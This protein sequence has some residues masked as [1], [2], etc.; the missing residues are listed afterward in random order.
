MSLAGRV[1]FLARLAEVQEAQ[2]W[3]PIASNGVGE[4]GSAASAP[5][6]GHRTTDSGNLLDLGPPGGQP[7]PPGFSSV[8][9]AFNG[10]LG[11]QPF[12]LAPNLIHHD[13]DA[14]TL[15]I[16]TPA[17]SDNSD[18]NDS[19]G[20]SVGRPILAEFHP[21]PHDPSAVLLSEQPV[22]TANRNGNSLGLSPF[23]G[24]SVA[25]E[26]IPVLHNSNTVLLGDQPIRTTN[27]DDGSS[28]STPPAGQPIALEFVPILHAPNGDKTCRCAKNFSRRDA[29]TRHIKTANKKESRTSTALPRVALELDQSLFPCG[30]CDKHQGQS[31]FAR[32]DHLRQHL[33][34]FHKLNDEAIN[35]CLDV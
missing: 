33:R 19:W 14:A 6:E 20:L 27:R 18:V 22:W 3:Q 2:Y 30:M 29:L 34:V 17:W 31:A 35:A 13:S 15:A 10:H 24:Q 12:P 21:V 1:S 25:P 26:F 23:T 5:T 28:G 4:P 8:L 16:N 32:R 11:G 9:H 7:S